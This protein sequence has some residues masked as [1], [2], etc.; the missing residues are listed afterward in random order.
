M[1]LTREMDYALRI[2]RAL[3]QEG[4]LSAAAIAG[5]E[6]MPKAVTL[7]I[8]KRLHAAGMVDSR[9]GSSGGYLLLRSCGELYLLDVVRALGEPLYVNRCQQPGYQC[10]N[11]TPDGCGLRREL[12]RIQ[13]V[14][15]AELS[16]TPLSVI[17]REEA[18][19]MEEARRCGGGSDFGKCKKSI[20]MP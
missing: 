12:S 11:R 20:E 9:R 14:L 18:A 6:H 7:K 17:F 5:R 10:E 8:L 19:D 1:L 16:R 15:D 13:Q 2:V 3:H 4:Q